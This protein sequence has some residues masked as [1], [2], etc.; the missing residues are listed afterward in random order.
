[1]EK[2]DAMDNS[3]SPP[4]AH[5]PEIENCPGKSRDHASEQRLEKFYSKKNFTKKW[6]R[7]LFSSLQG[8]SRVWGPHFLGHTKLKKLWPPMLYYQNTYLQ[9]KHKLG[10]EEPFNEPKQGKPMWKNPR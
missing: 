3:L 4:Q 9:L 7:N 1:M 8:N 6:S 5:T 2:P 10:T